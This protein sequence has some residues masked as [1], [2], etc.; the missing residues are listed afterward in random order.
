MLYRSV[1]KESLKVVWDFPRGTVVKSP[2]ANAGDT[3]LHPGPGRSHM[4]QNNK[5]RAPQLLSLRSRAH[6]PQ[7]LSPYATTTEACTPR[8]RALQQE[9]PP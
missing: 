4:L 3:V 6:E 9:K 8:A 2:P 7:L 5:A 1:K